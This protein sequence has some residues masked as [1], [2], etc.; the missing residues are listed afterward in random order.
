MMMD[1]AAKFPFYW[2]AKIQRNPKKKK[3]T[4]KQKKSNALE[5]NELKNHTLRSLCC[6]A[7]PYPRSVAYKGI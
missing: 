3:D 5:I 4:M 1:L 7:F 6:I 2:T